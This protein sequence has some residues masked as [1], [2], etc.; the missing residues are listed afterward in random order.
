[1][2][3]KQKE[4]VMK[5]RERGLT[6]RHEK[7]GAAFQPYNKGVILSV[8]SDG[9]VFL[10]PIFHSLHFKLK[11]LKWFCLFCTMTC[12]ECISDMLNIP[13]AQLGLSQNVS[14]HFIST[15]VHSVRKYSLWLP[16]IECS[17]TKIN[18][19][20]A[21]MWLWPSVKYENGLCSLLLW[22][23]IYAWESLHDMAVSH[24]LLCDLCFAFVFLLLY[25]WTIVYMDIKPKQSGVNCTCE[26]GVASRRARRFALDELPAHWK[27]NIKR[28][29][30][31]WW[32]C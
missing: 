11:S 9:D 3:R 15:L 21:K 2:Q 7:T 16:H 31:V 30:Q 28:C 10:F 1:M 5:K 25:I 20:L 22:V 8:P 27:A 26:S 24:I 17:G 32:Y 18:N 12:R 14:S 6:R 29:S 13:L 4:A 23:Y 19:T